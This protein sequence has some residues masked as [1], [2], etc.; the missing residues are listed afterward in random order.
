MKYSPRSKQQSVPYECCFKTSIKSTILTPSRIFRRQRTIGDVFNIFFQNDNGSSGS[1]EKHYRS[2]IIPCTIPSKLRIFKLTVLHLLL[3][4]HT[5]QY[6]LSTV[7]Y[8]PVHPLKCREIIL[9]WLC[10]LQST[11]S[12]TVKSTSS[13]TV[14]PYKPCSLD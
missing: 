1:H 9:S 10:W 11:S 4:L 2:K 13:R 3:A 7:I 12:N 5:K 6:R 14:N 8:L